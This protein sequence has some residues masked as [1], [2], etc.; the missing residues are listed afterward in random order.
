MTYYLI[1]NKPV[2]IPHITNMLDNNVAVDGFPNSFETPRKN[3][4]SAAPRT[5][6]TLGSD[7]QQRKH[8]ITTHTKNKKIPPCGKGYLCF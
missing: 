3:H 2:S 6:V 1:Q 5:Q 4:S 7:K 8:N